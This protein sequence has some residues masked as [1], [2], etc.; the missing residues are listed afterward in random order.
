L[1]GFSNHHGGGE[2]IAGKPTA[3]SSVI[4]CQNEPSLPLAASGANLT[5]YTRADTTDA[6]TTAPVPATT[7]AGTQLFYVL[8]T[9]SFGCKSDTAR[10]QVIVHPSISGNTIEKDQTLCEGG[11][12]QALTPRFSIGGGNGSYTY[13]WQ[14]STNGGTTWTTISGAS[15]STYSPGPSSA[16]TTYRRIVSSSNCRDTSAAVTITIQGT[17][18]NTGISA[19]QTICSGT[20]PATLEGQQ[21]S[22]GS[23]SY[24]YSWESSTDGSTWTTIADATSK[25]YSPPA[26]TASIFYRRKVGSGE[27]SIYSSP[28]KLPL[29][30]HRNGTCPDVTV[31]HNTTT[32]T[33]SFSA[34][35]ATGVSFRWVNDNPLIGL[36]PAGTGAIPSFTAVN[37]SSPKKAVVANI[38]VTP[39]YTG[40]GVECPGTP[41]TFRITV[42]PTISIDLI[43]LV[44]TCTG[45]AIAALTPKPDTAFYA[46]ATVSYVW[47]VTGSG[48]S[49]Q[50]SSGTQIPGYGTENTGTSDLVATIT[51]TPRYT[52]N[53]RTCDGQAVS[54]TVTV[55]PSTP[56]AAAGADAVLCA[57][58]SYTLRASSVAGTTGTWTQISGPAA[59]IV[60]QTSLPRLSAG[61]RQVGFIVLYGR[62]P[63]SLAV[64]P[65]PIQ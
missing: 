33:I 37:N 41:V 42:L 17:L 39:V 34:T 7:S 2:S 61:C 50:S 59:E 24:L 25:D 8:Q 43:P 12:P 16:T 48:I 36:Q 30:R 11:T 38:T 14:S 6:S 46:G 10:I 40:G 5:W 13:Q 60:T 53:N 51:V 19:A 27:C 18:T 49:L 9:N 31:C 15:S 1:F 22:G 32:G 45:T 64:H 35:P 23:G 44:E 3:P 29:T 26:L 57:A 54:Y 21:P 52:L 55:K 65:P 4:Y 63:A 47:T 62:K 56:P 58:P 20:R 28:V